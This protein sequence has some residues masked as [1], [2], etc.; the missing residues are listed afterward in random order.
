MLDHLRGRP[1]AARG[2]AAHAPR[3]ARLPRAGAAELGH[4]L[5]PALLNSSC[6]PTFAASPVASL[7][8]CGSASAHSRRCRAGGSP[9]PRCFAQLLGKRDAGAPKAFSLFLALGLLTS[10]TVTPLYVPALATVVGHVISNDANVARWFAQITFVLAIKSQTRVLQV[11]LNCLF[12]PM[13][14]G[15]LG[16]ALSVVSFVGVAAPFAIV[17]VATNAITDSVLTQLRLCLACASIGEA[18][19]ALGCALVLL[20]LN[21]ANAAEVVHARAHSDAASA[22]PLVMAQ[23]IARRC[24]RRPV[25]RQDHHAAAVSRAQSCDCARA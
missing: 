23:S 4:Y 17:A 25:A 1:A 18:V 11:T 9:S 10:L 21:W 22:T 7:A 3:G 16:V 14:L 15:R 5:Q 13:G 8:R 19:N 6:S 20:R 2:P 24:R 12:V